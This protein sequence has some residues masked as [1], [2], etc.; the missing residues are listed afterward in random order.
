MDARFCIQCQTSLVQ[1]CPKCKS[2]L[3]WHY[4]NCHLCG[5]N[6]ATEQKLQQQRALEERERQQKLTQEKEATLQAK[7]TKHFLTARQL[8]D[9]GKWRLAK[10]ELSCFAGLGPAKADEKAKGGDKQTPLC[11]REHPLWVEAKALN[12]AADATHR[13]RRGAIVKTSGIVWGVISFVVT[14]VL[15]LPGAVFPDDLDS[16]ALL[17]VAIP[18]GI[19]IVAAVCTLVWIEIWGGK[20]RRHAEQTIGLFAPLFMSLLLLTGIGAIG[21]VLAFLF[22]G[23]SGGG[24]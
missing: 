12:D 11:G 2:E 16:L 9:D 5:C 3:P 21:V 18:V 20:N 19:A 13:A 24:G 23:G 6:I 17:G 22:L 10:Q 14:L 1:A 7:I 15:M 4:L 8:L